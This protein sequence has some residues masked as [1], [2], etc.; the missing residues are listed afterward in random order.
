MTDK[1]RFNDSLGTVDY[2]VDDK[3]NNKKDT[4]EIAK[5]ILIG[6]T[7]YFIF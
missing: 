3:S 1:Y 5:M 6:I 7:I 2:S 4:N